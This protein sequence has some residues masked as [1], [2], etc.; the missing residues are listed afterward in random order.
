MTTKQKVHEFISKYMLS[1][2][3]VV[4]ILCISFANGSFLTANNILNI[5]RTMSMKGIVAFG[6]TF[7]IIAGE[8]DLSIGSTIGLSGVILQEL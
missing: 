2:I 5:L 3:L 6:M 8:I 4:L 1:I 7:V